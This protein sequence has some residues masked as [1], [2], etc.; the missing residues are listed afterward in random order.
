MQQTI[1]GNYRVGADNILLWTIACALA[2]A[3]MGIAATAFNK[4]I[5][6]ADPDATLIHNITLAPFLGAPLLCVS[7]QWYA[8]KRFAPRLALWMWAGAAVVALVS[9][10][11]LPS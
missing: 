2:P 1:P 6:T 4:E 11:F 10:A 8:L 5:L 9:S 3:L 7:L